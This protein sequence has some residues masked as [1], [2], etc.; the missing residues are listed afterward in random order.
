LLAPE[1]AIA[2]MPFVQDG[3]LGGPNITPC[4]GWM[5]IDPTPFTTAGVPVGET[6]SVTDV[7]GLETNSP[8]R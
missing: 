4:S 3:V 1:D 6:Q 7:F 5:A 8:A 2:F